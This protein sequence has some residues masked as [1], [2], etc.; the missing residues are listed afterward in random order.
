MSALNNPSVLWT[1]LSKTVTFDGGVG[2]GAQGTVLVFTV[3]GQVEIGA[4][5]PRSLV[6]PVGTGGT[7]VLGTAGTINLFVASTVGT[8]MTGGK[9]W[10]PSI[11]DELALPAALKE[12]ILD[13]NIILTIGVHD[14]SAGSLRFDILWRPLSAGALVA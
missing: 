3:T 5:V 6:T 8:T 11:V 2:S 9:F 7:L 1:P 13:G 10:L 4:M 14:L 12:I